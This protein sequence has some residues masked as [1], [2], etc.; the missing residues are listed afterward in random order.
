MAQGLNW[1]NNVIEIPLPNDRMNGRIV[2]ASAW[3][4]DDD[5]S[6]PDG[7]AVIV[8]L[9]LEPF[10]E[11]ETNYR[12]VEYIAQEGDWKK[13]CVHGEHFNIVPATEQ[14]QDVSGCY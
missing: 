12:I 5:A 2:I 11:G 13:V 7:I 4:R 8:T 3:F 9:E 6:D 10:V 14:Y 1:T